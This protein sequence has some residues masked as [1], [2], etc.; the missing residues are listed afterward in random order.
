MKLHLRDIRLRNNA[1]IDFPVCRT[2]G[3]FLDL[4]A[5]RYPTASTEDYEK[6]EDKSI[7][8]KHCLRKW[9][10]RYDWCQIEVGQ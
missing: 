9:N 2:G 3:E 10:K 6:A 7:F 5:T 8:C 1:G 4:E